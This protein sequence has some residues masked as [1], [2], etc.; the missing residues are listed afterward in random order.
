[1]VKNPRSANSW[2]IQET[3]QWP[4][5]T[6]SWGLYWSPKAPITKHHKL[7]DLMQQKFFSHGSFWRAEV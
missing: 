7:D 1:M 3:A 5:I 6:G 2:A 4:N